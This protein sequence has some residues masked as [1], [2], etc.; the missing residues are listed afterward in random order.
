MVK[1]RD[2][3]RVDTGRK[4]A[5]GAPIYNWIK[6]DDKTVDSDLMSNASSDFKQDDNITINDVVDY[7][8][9]NVP[10]IE[11]DLEE[12][13]S[14]LNKN[15]ILSKK[16]SEKLLKT[17]IDENIKNDDYHNSSSQLSLDNETRELVD[18]S[19]DRLK[20]EL[21]NYNLV[22]LTMS[23]YKVK[24][25]KQLYDSVNEKLSNNNIISRNDKIK[26]IS[27]SN[28]KYVIDTTNNSVSLNSNNMKSLL[29]DYELE[30]DSYHISSNNTG[31]TTF[32]QD[33]GVNRTITT[34]QGHS[35][36]LPSRIGYQRSTSSQSSPEVIEE[37]KDLDVD[38]FKEY[39]GLISEKQA[40]RYAES[41]EYDVTDEEKYYQAMDYYDEKMFTI[42]NEE[43]NNFDDIPSKRQW[44]NIK[45][46]LNTIDD[47]E[48]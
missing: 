37:M 32:V 18:D 2:G 27:I 42:L 43:L 46:R 23:D 15:M 48:F 11:Y 21:Y 8:S 41:F 7:Y 3:K 22:Y 45:H 14:S 34:S 4:K 24:D 6:N 12:L 16:D 9:E 33:N 1:K 20:E 25:D 44:D 31:D 35:Y 10:D 36:T 17:I 26:N 40:S 38:N 28:G 13:T 19:H 47:P 29:L 30:D 39:L 5:N